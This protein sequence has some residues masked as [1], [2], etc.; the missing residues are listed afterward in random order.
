MQ[1]IQKVQ[2][3]EELWRL[4]QSWKQCSV[5]GQSWLFQGQTGLML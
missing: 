5:Q 3:P 2:P 4:S 1:D